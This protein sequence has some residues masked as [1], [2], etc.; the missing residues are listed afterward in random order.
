MKQMGVGGGGY[1]VTVFYKLTL[2]LKVFQHPSSATVIV[3]VCA[4]T[5]VCKRAHMYDTDQ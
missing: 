4:H 3:C 2:S 5:Y 1:S